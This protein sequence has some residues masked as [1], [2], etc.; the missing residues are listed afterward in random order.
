MIKANVELFLRVGDDA[1]FLSR[2]L[3]ALK[4]RGDAA[5]AALAH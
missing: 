2:D 1:D 3:K 4:F 5:V